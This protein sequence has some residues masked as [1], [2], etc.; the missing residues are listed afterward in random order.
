MKPD[1]IHDELAIIKNRLTLQR[2]AQHNLPLLIMSG[3]SL[4][5]SLVFLML[6]LLSSLT[7]MAF[8]SYMGYMALGFICTGIFIMMTTLMLFGPKGILAKKYSN[9]LERQNLDELSEEEL[10]TLISFHHS[11]KNFDA[12]DRASKYLM[13]KVESDEPHH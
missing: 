8:S 2:L 11:Q 3:A 7:K 13:L 12:A 5:L 10:Q 1:K 4:A 6:A 9:Q